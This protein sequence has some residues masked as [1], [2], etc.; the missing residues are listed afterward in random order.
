M[1]KETLKVLTLK[2]LIFILLGFM[3]SSCSIMEKMF[4]KKVVISY[5][6]VFVP[7]EGGINFV[8]IT[9]DADNVATPGYNAT[10][11]THITTKPSTSGVSWYKY[12]VISIIPNDEKIGYIS[13]RNDV[14]NVMIKSATQ[15]SGSIQQTFRSDVRN[16]TFSP[17]GKKVCYTEYR[18][19]NLG[20]FMMDVNKGTVTQRISPTG[21]QDDGPSI[22][23]DG[24]TI[25]FDRYEG[26]FNFGLWSYDVKTGLFS[27]YSHGYTP[28]VDPKND[29]II[30]IA[31]YTFDDK[32]STF[33]TPSTIYL[34]NDKSRRSEIWKLDT[35]KGTEE[36]LL[37]DKMSSFSCPQVSPDGKWILV[38]GANKANNGVWNTNIFVIRSD[39]TKF[40]QL[41]YHPGNDMSGIW[42][43]DGKSIYFISQRGTEKGL[44]NVWKMDF[45][46]Q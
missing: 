25:F 9:T 20:L 46:L 6:T 31:R 22:S 14:T 10:S 7:E 27:N 12:P 4:K 35:E 17:D 36:L 45:Q 13:L 41:T 24:N 26:N 2:S 37:S 39:G 38:T 18:D 23:K 30:Y 28:C 34:T 33:S 3:L 32:V 29:K 44:Y 8:K 21:S 5:A 42:S 19:G 40:T 43:K 15:G 11:K 16:F 1:E